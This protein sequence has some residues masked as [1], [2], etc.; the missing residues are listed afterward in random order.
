MMFQANSD[1]ALRA[2]KSD[3]LETVGRKPLNDYIR[4]IRKPRGV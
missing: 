1:S 3:V 4:R 2:S